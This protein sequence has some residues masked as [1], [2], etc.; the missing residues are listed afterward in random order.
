[1]A[2]IIGELEMSIVST[3]G[4]LSLGQNW[5]QRRRLEKVM[6]RTIDVSADAT[7]VREKKNFTV[8]ILSIGTRSL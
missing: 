6:H 4:N 1:M 3:I 5:S 2:N 7:G 8:D